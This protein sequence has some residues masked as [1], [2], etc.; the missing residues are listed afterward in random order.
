M[1]KVGDRVKIRK[2]SRFYGVHA[3]EN[4]AEIEGTVIEIDDAKFLNHRVEWKTGYN[5]NHYDEK[6]LQHII[7]DNPLNRKLYPN[8]ISKDGHLVSKSAAKI[9]EENSCNDQENNL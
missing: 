8:F 9:N 3:I 1:F 5:T 4:P 2:G 7:L 6:D